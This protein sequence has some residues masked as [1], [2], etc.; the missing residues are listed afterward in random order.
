MK[1]S[2]AVL[3]DSQLA[4]LKAIQARRAHNKIDSYYPAEGPL[5]R[6]L[7]S[8]HLSFFSAGKEHRERAFIAA[9]RVGKTEGVGGYEVA[10]HMTGRYP[11]WWEGKRF[12]EPVRVW[13]CGDTAKSVRNI[14]QVKMLGPIRTMG[15][16]MIP[17]DELV[18]TVK[19]I[20]VPDAIELAYVRHRSG[21]TSMM[22]F[23]S[24][25]QRREA[26]QGSDLDIIWLDEEPPMDIYAECLVRLMTTGGILLF[27]FTPLE[28]LTELVLSFL[29][30]GR[31]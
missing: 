4:N 11:E 31:V 9:N 12:E 7:Y 26:F 18:H 20:G 1:A 24:Y 10:C 5:R 21:K 17:G 15:T 25:D 28:G 14:L 27:T 22:T 29:P 16:G 30:G 6:E 3:L 19:K 23:M 2:E 8:K 13:A